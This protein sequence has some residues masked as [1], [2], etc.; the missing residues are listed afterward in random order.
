MIFVLAFGWSVFYWNQAT[1]DKSFNDKRDD[2]YFSCV[3]SQSVN[4]REPKVC[5]PIKEFSRDYYYANGAVMASRM[6]SEC[7][8]FKDSGINGWQEKNPDCDPE[9]MINLLSV[10]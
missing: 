4:G 1:P 5:D 6:L 10:Q 2:S 9:T 8:M 3:Q 7:R